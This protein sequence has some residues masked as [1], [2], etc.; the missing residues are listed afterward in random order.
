M[1]SQFAFY[2]IKFS[3]T[4]PEEKMTAVIGLK[5]RLIAFY[6]Q[7]FQGSKTHKNKELY[8]MF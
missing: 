6:M 7:V 2:E 1:L 3:M 5:F 8:L 4:E